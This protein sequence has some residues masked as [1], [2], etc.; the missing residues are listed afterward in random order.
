ML[1][2]NKVTAHPTVDF[3]AEELK[4]YL[5]M[6]MPEGGDV[7]IALNPL[8]DDGFRLG[9]MESFGLP[10]LEGEV[11]ELDDVIY[12]DCDERGGVI[13]GANPRAVLLAVYE[14]LRQNGCRWLFPGIDG[15]FIPMQDI[16]PVKLRHTPSMRY[17]GQ[18]IEGQA[19]QDQQLETVDFLPK[20]GMNLYMM[21]FEIPPHYR[22]YDHINNSENLVP[23]VASNS[24]KLQWKRQC[25]AEIAKR[26]L[27]FHDIGHG[28]T[29]K[30]FGIKGIWTVEEDEP[31]ARK[32]IAEINGERPIIN[33]KPVYTNFCM[34]NR[35]ARRIVAEYIRDFSK[36]H[37]NIDYLHVWLADGANKHCECEECRKKLPSDFYVELMNE[38]D[39]LLSEAG[40]DTKIVFICYVDTFWAPIRERIKNPDRFALLFAP[41]HRSYAHSLPKNRAKRALVPY[42]RN[43]NVF[44]RDLAS[45]LDYLDEWK[46]SYNGPIIAFEYHFWRH[47]NYSISGQMQARLLYDDVKAY[48]DNGLDGIIQ[49]GSQR[50]L[51]PSALR[52]YTFAMAMYDKELSYEEIEADY[53]YHLYGEDWK[54]FRAYLLKLEEA[55]PFDFFSR[56]SARLR[57]SCHTDSV[58][59]KSIARIREI[60]KEGR[61]LIKEH[62]NSDY[63]VRTVGVRLLEK[64]AEYCDLTSDWIGAKARGEFELAK[65]LFEIARVEFGKSEVEIRRYFDH[66]QVFGEFYHT[67]AVESKSEV[68]GVQI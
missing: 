65:K 59:A 13:S 11:R 16:V 20:I 25:E 40:I 22:Y 7:E 8:A 63:R 60:T 61:R 1:T 19:Y 48:G 47:Y 15:E 46:K 35:E 42:N 12:I 26:S 32:F 52:M 54:D 58:M 45:S 18:C 24:Q 41:I 50:A 37:L 21:Q 29:S 9:L 49:C 43:K 2:I 3:A 56:D 6:M 57:K 23:E 55:L 44:P 5:R 68:A 62:Y 53:L 4:K 14:Y 30:P 66:G 34:S 10:L 38:T 28:F 31:E 27:Q 51:F 36:K 39:E 33:G 17:R 64:H 67:L